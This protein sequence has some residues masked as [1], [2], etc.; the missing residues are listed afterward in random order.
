MSARDVALALAALVA[1]AP[2][3]GHGRDARGEIVFIDDFIRDPELRTADW[4]P[5]GPAVAATLGR[6]SAA[7][8]AMAAPA[9]RFDSTHGLTLSAASSAGAQSGIQTQFAYTP[10]FRISATGTADAAGP[11]T[12]EFALATADANA[13]LAITAGQG[14]DALTSGFALL[15]PA[16]PGQMWRAP[17][18]QSPLSSQAPAAGTGYDF[19]V[20]VDAD[21]MA[22]VYVQSQGKVLGA[23]Q[24][25]IGQ[26]PFYV[27]VGE[28]SGADAAGHPNQAH[29]RGVTI[30]RPQ[31]L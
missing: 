10:P 3:S 23:A 28:A 1:L 11:G 21:G 22:H 19:L 9:M 12:L 8:P 4:Q 17:Q 27:I 20:D 6:L 13:G 2:A 25:Q 31:A 24:V 26:G 14:A 5:N 7:T 18:G 16:G 30:R 15:S 29:W